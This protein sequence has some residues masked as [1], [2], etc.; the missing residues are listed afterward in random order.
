MIKGG[1]KAQS[2]K[3]SVAGH[4]NKSIDFTKARP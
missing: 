2:G 3:N 4:V 1:F